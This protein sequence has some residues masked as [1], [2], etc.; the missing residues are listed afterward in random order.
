MTR[1]TLFEEI[2]PYMSGYLPVGDGHDIYYEECGRASG[3]PVVVL[4]GGP[5]SGFSPIHRQFFD[6]DY[7]RIILFDQRGAGKSRPSGALNNNTIW[8]LVADIERLRT[9]LN[10]DSWHVFGGSWGSTLAIAYAEEHPAVCRSLILRGIFLMQRYEID[11]MF[12]HMR[13]VFP[14]NWDRFINFL[15]AAE[16]VTPLPNYYARLLNPDPAIHKPA[17]DHWNHFENTCSLLIPDPTY[18]IIDDD[19]AGVA[20]ARIE[21]HYFLHNLFEPDDLLLSR[22]DRIRHI[23]AC[24]IQGRY[25]MICPIITADRLHQAWPEADYVIVPDGG[26]S[27]NDPPVRRALLA[28]TERL[29]TA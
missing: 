4:H 6:P 2:A 29:K 26:H 12:Q 24:I 8:D 10:I 21:C 23:P 27:Q 22:I 7:Y 5:G 19:A 14:E 1:A 25:D 16:Q 20:R 11:W 28:A 13:H 17:A 18:S 3:V 15:P 9:H